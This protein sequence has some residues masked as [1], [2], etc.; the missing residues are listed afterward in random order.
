MM[1]LVST[2]LQQTGLPFSPRQYWRFSI[3]FWGSFALLS[4]GQGTLVQLLSGRPMLYT[5][6]LHWLVRWGLWIL[7][8]PVF[9]YA[10]CRLPILNSGPAGPLLKSVLYHFLI[11]TAYCLVSTLVE[12]V[13]VF[14]LYE[15]ESGRM[16]P[17]QQALISLSARY[18]VMAAIYMLIVLGY[19]IVLYVHRFQLLKDQNSEYEL[20]TE[21]LKAQVANA[22]LQA[23]KMQLNPHF[24]FNTLNSIVGLMIA[25]ENRKAISM[26][27][28]LSELL[29]TIVDSKDVHLVPLREEIDII[30]KYLHIQHIRFE[31]RLQVEL[32]IDPET[33]CCLVPHYILQ[34]LVE[35]A[36][37]HGIESKASEALIRITTRRIYDSLIVEVYDNG[38]GLSSKKPNKRHGVGIASVRQRLERLYGPAGQLSFEP[39]AGAGTLAVLMIPCRPGRLPIQ[40][41]THDTLESPDRR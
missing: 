11:L 9:L 5:D 33:E 7:A 19:N 23:L 24:L 27:N 35:N 10:A 32:E 12:Y 40:T 25:R 20:K 14:R 39:P 6:T 4:Y 22:Q 37:V 16:M 17:V 1:S 31:D 34:P 29:R 13:L 3:L 30:K 15:L 41:L 21:Q 26:V 8:N 38:T 2:I 36:V 28:S 18:T